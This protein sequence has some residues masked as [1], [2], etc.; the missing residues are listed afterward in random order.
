MTGTYRRL[1]EKNGN[2]KTGKVTLQER[3]LMS[4]SKAENQGQEHSKLRNI[5]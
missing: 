1:W 4:D 3:V 5:G 2:P